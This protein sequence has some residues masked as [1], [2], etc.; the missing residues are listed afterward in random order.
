M[1]GRNLFWLQLEMENLGPGRWHISSTRLP[2]QMQMLDCLRA[3]DLARHSAHH[4]SKICR[5]PRQT[6]RPFYPGQIRRKEI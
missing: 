1:T 2:P 4:P 5:L 6:G 3:G